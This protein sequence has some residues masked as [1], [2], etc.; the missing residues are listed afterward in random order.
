M[1]CTLYLIPNLLLRSNFLPYIS[2]QCVER[3]VAPEEILE[4]SLMGCSFSFVLGA[5]HSVAWLEHAVA[6]YQ[7]G[8]VLHLSDEAGVVQHTV[9]LHTVTPSNASLC[10]SAAAKSTA[11]ALKASGTALL[12]AADANP[13]SWQQAIMEY[14]RALNWLSWSSGDDTSPAD[15]SLVVSIRLNLA[16]ANLRLK[17]WDR[18]AY[19]CDA[20]LAVQPDNAKALYRRSRSLFERGL[21]QPAICDARKAARIVPDDRAV[22]QLLEQATDKQYALVRMNRQKFAEVYAN[23]VQ[24]PLFNKGVV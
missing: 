5:G 22:A 12:T 10:S 18:A 11:E 16:L 7:A 14:N 24:S 17:M 2:V 4:D 19:Q 20:I 15:L 3:S 23:M 8:D 21:Y 1:V 9:V 6:G 13:K